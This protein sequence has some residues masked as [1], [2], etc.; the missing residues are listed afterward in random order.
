MSAIYRAGAGRTGSERQDVARPPADA[1]STGSA[2]E[3]LLVGAAKRSITPTVLGRRVY[4]AGYR[5]GRL[6]TDIHDE[7]WVRAVAIRCREATLILVALDLIGLFHEDVKAIRSKVA[8][9]G[10]PTDGLIV[11]CT[12]NHSGPDTLGLWRRGPRSLGR[13]FRYTDFLRTQVAQVIRLAYEAM[14][15]AQ[16][17]LACAEMDELGREAETAGLSVM[18]LRTLTGRQVATVVNGPLVP[19]VLQ[20]ANTAISA[21]FV[22]WLYLDLERARDDIV[23]YVCAEAGEPSPVRE[24]SWSEAERI[25]CQ[26]ASMVQRA[27]D[28]A[29]PMMISHLAVWRKSIAIPPDRRGLPWPVNAGGRLG[30]DWRRESE[31]GVVEFGPL[32]MIA[33]PGLAAPEM[34][35]EL[36]KALDAPYRWLLCQSNDSLGTIRLRQGQPRSG[37]LASGP[38]SLPDRSGPCVRVGSYASTI[39]MDQVADLMLEVRGR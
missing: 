6:A 38:G 23:L 32:R 19:Q 36:R 31:V 27:V 39:I 30:G 8:A 16:A 15:P 34:G 26:L 2:H 24:H 12:G 25:G 13:S 3:L 21:D 22:N 5:R 28:S 29:P 14:E 33:V 18:Q 11:T 1:P 37:E 35:F 7:L 17:Y 9:A 4:L 10:V 20:E